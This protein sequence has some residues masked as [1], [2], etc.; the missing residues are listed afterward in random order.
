M[1]KSKPVSNTE[2]PASLV[3]LPELRDLALNTAGD[4]IFSRQQLV[5]LLIDPKRD[6][7][8][9]C[10]YP[11][12]I[13]LEMYSHLYDR[14]DLCAR[15]VDILPE[16]SW[17]KTPEVT[18]NQSGAETPFEK[19]WKEIQQK[20]NLFA[21]MEEVDKASGV[22]RFG[23]ILLGVEDGKTL[24]VPLAG[25][26]DDG[27]FD[28]EKKAGKTRELLYIRVFDETCVEVAEWETDVT[29]A[30]FDQPKFYS[31]KFAATGGRNLYAKRVHWTRII[32][33]A[34]NKRNSEVYGRPRMQLV[35]NRLYD[36][37]KILGGA[38]EMFWKGGFPGYSVEIA[39][40]LMKDGVMPTIDNTAVKAELE[41]YFNQLQRY[42]SM[43][44][45]TMK[46]ISPQVEDPTPHFKMAIVAMCIALGVPYRIFMGT[47]EAQLAGDQDSRSWRDRLTHRIQLHVEPY[48]ARP[49]IDRLIACGVLEM[50][51]EGEYFLNWPDLFTLSDT[52]KAD[53]MV[54]ATEAMVKYLAGGVA[55]AGLMGPLEFL[56][57]I[58][59]FSQDEA[60]DILEKAI[61]YVEENVNTP[62]EDAQEA[63]DAAALMM[64]ATTPAAGE[65]TTETE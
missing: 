12:T 15:I 52:E 41:A 28:P 22:G 62:E 38:A 47:E 37:R 51:G 56:T 43:Q 32:H 57:H 23:V 16:E 45:L 50:P 17:K 49:L 39:P 19:R 34:D 31:V 53:L 46:S 63:A 58:M 29:S 33:V 20:H 25:V 44:G 60:E 65:D 21:K 27:R 11:E 8:S 54:K 36:L 18:S 4:T 59:E 26:G 1:K 40:E 10:G 13:E 6:I 5:K 35:F 48:I 3:S 14:G 7:D 2:S 24:G 9:E 42:F 30:R 61:Q 55:E 64:E